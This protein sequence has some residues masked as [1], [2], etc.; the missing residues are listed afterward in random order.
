MDVPRLKTRALESHKGTFGRALIVGGSR[1]MSGAP[2]L[3]AMAA[4]RAGA[5]LVT[6]AVPDR[7]L[8]T[9]ASF[10]PCYMAIPLPEDEIGRVSGVASEDLR[11]LSYR[12]TSVGI[13]PG[14]SQSDGVS[15]VVGDLYER[16][17]E[18]MVVDADALNALA[19]RPDGLPSAGPRI[20]TP[21]IGEFRRM[22]G[23]ADLS[24]NDC[25]EAARRFAEQHKVIIVLKGHRTLV[26]DGV[27]EFENTT[28]N[29]GMATGGSGDVL[30]GVITA[31][32]GQAYTPWEAAVLAVHVHGL[33]GDIAR[34]RVGETS[35]T[36]MHIVAHL[37]D[38]FL[39]IP[40]EAG[41][42]RG[43]MGF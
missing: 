4:L 8:E 21:H 22:V 6:V 32:T 27:E 38:A 42:D 2:A 26:T 23:D 28:G 16:Y 19:G 18:P 41:Q 24:P 39:K 17:R 40:R 34:D 25:R 3:A 1:G 36:A 29:P 9:V 7:C 14:M 43:Q 20:L 37:G 13:G 31:L 35:L 11:G 10:D 33:A 5:G 30:T 12:A 15:Q